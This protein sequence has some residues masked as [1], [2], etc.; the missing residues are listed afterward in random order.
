MGVRRLASFSAPGRIGARP[1]GGEMR[2]GAGLTAQYR[3]PATVAS[4]WGS[5]PA[6][7]PAVGVWHDAQ[8]RSQS[9]SA[10]LSCVEA[11]CLPE[12]EVSDADGGV[13]GSCLFEVTGLKLDS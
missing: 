3:M 10:F 13:R 5:L 11:V 1:P 2:H 4:P 9:H 7:S 8:H 12:F 6:P